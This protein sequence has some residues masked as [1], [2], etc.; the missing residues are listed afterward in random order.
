MHVKELTALGGYIDDLFITSF[1]EKVTNLVI[2]GYHYD[3]DHFTIE[4]YMNWSKNKILNIKR[5]VYDINKGNFELLKYQL[6]QTD[7]NYLTR[8]DLTIDEKWQTWYDKIMEVINEN[9]PQKTL[10]K[11]N[12]PPWID[13]ECMKLIQK[14]NRTLS[15]ARKTKNPETEKKFRQLR[16]RIKNVISHKAN[17]Y[18]NQL[19]ENLHTNPKKFWSYLKTKRWSK[20]SPSL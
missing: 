6:R 20:E 13:L 14:K 9:I 12:T 10:G 7:Y 18:I 4:V 15:K 3:S 1:P 2:R 19:C 11:T 16:N 5:K 8:Q 17:N